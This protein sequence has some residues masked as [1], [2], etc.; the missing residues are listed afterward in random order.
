[1]QSHPCLAKESQPNPGIYTRKTPR[2]RTLMK[3]SNFHYRQN[4]TSAYYHY[5][6]KIE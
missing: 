4:N 6:M 3:E 2:T 5:N 1:M